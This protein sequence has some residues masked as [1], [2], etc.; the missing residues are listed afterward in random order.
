[1]HD[2]LYNEVGVVGESFDVVRILFVLETDTYLFSKAHNVTPLFKY[3]CNLGDLFSM[4]TCLIVLSDRT[5]RR[6]VF[7]GKERVVKSAPAIASSS[8][9]TAKHASS[10]KTY[11]S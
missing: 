11:A 7:Y 6:S 5:A 10:L 1:M 2:H 9:K 3:L 8:L 4:L